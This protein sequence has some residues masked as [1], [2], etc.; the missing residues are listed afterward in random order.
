MKNLIKKAKKGDNGAFGQ[1]YTQSATDFY[2]FALYILKN[3]SDA[4]DAVQNAAIYAYRKIGMLKNDDSF[5]AWFLRILYNE[6]LKISGAKFRKNETVTEDIFAFDRE[7][8]DTAR[9]S[10]ALSLLEG[11][12]ENDRAIIVLSVLEDYNSSEISEILGIPSATVRSKLS[13]LLT[14]LRKQIE[15]ENN[16]K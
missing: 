15:G 4:E 9:E 14:K 10:D 8:P 5:K 1:L 13:R 12:P 16:E 6:C 11:L 3:H 7:A 2:R